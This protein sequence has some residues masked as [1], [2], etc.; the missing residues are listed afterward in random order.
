MD[1]V[2]Y[3]TLLVAVCGGHTDVVCALVT[4]GADVNLKCNDWF[5]PLIAVSQEG[6]IDIVKLF[7]K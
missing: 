1:K 5:S 6:H 3:T 2:V 7:S 4:A